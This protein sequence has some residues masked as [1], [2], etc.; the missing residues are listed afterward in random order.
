MCRF[1]HFLV[2]YFLVPGVGEG[3]R[4]RQASH[5][6]S[7]GRVLFDARGAGAGAGTGTGAEAGVTAGAGPL[8]LLVW[9]VLAILATRWLDLLQQPAGVVSEVLKMF[10]FQIQLFDYI[11]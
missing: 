11:F 6:V 4:T 2:C 9:P 1:L 7:L 5:R 10:R 8:L 3:F